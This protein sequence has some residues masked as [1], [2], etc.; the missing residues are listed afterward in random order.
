MTCQCLTAA[1]GGVCC[2]SGVEPTRC[3]VSTGLALDIVLEGTDPSQ[4]CKP[5]PSNVCALL[6]F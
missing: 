1:V 2:E 6:P 5:S 3:D 4:T